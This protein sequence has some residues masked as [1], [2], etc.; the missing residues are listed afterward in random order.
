MIDVSRLKHLQDRAVSVFGSFCAIHGLVKVWIKGLAQW[1]N[2][3]DAKLSQII[4]E[5]FINQLEALAV[6]RVFVILV[7]GQRVLKAVHDGNQ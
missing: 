3:F 1:F 5:L 6:T 2:T 4:Q 7:R